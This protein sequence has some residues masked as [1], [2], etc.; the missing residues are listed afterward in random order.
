L[1]L[2]QRTDLA[3]VIYDFSQKRFN[4]WAGFYFYASNTQ[5]TSITTTPGQ[6]YY[7]LPGTMRNVRMI[8]LNMGS[9]WLVLDKANFNGIYDILQSDVTI[10]PIT[11]LPSSWAQFGLT[12]R[13]F[14]VPDRAY[15]LELTGNNA[16]PIPTLDQ[17]ENFWTE[18]AD[19]GQLIVA[20]T[21][22]YIF[23]E[24]L[25]APDRAAPYEQEVLLQRYKLTKVSLDLGGPKVARAYGPGFG[26]QA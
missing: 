11:T 15:N 5:D 6:I 24:Y 4:Y 23:K 10:P 8:R 7:N 13:L 3:A 20:D 26:R 25:G 12:F 2:D 21:V 17:D 19:A 22:A 1:R 14:P 9:V 16:P 18:D